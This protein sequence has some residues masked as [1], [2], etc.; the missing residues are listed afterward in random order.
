MQST[1]YIHVK[2]ESMLL[3]AMIMAVNAMGDWALLCNDL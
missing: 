1:A 3:F 2:A